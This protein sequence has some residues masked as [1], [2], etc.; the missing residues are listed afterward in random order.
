MVVGINVGGKDMSK[1]VSCGHQ[2]GGG[3]DGSKT[4]WLWASM[5]GVR[6]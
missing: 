5:L 1:T 2:W 3:Q 6:I 4:G